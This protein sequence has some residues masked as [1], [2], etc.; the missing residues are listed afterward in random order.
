MKRLVV[1]VFIALL[2]TVPAFAQ[3][4]RGHGYRLRGGNLFQ[5]GSEVDRLVQNNLSLVNRLSSYS[6]GSYYG[7]PSNLGYAVGQVVYGTT[8]NY[9]AA[10]RTAATVEGGMAIGTLIYER[11]QAKKQRQQEETYSQMMKEEQQRQES[12]RTYYKYKFINESGFDGVIVIL[13][14]SPVDINGNGVTD[15]GDGLKNGESVSVGLDQPKPIQA[16]FWENVRW[17]NQCP[18]CPKG[19][20]YRSEPAQVWCRI[21]IERTETGGRVVHILPPFK[22]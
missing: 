12:T 21:D 6:Y 16:Y 22:N 10:Y 11:R 5:G 14:D 8:G 19:S 1:F 20:E 2:V 18:N 4:H 17:E 9:R 13:D 15:A 7:P 3:G